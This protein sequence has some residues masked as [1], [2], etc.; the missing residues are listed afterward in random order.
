MDTIP[1]I[2]TSNVDSGGGETS[3]NSLGT[4]SSSS[5]SGQN[6]SITPLI[7]SPTPSSPTVQPKKKSIDDF[8]IGKV[9]GEGSYGAVVLGTD[10]ETQVQYAIKILEKKHIIKEN[11]IKYV[12][13][14]K[15]IF[16]KCNHPN[17]VKLFFT[18]RSDACLYYVLE[19]CSQG[20]LLHQLK[21]VG[22]FDA[23]CTRYYIAEIISAVEHL[24]QLGIVHRDLK[25]EN[26][27]MSADMHIK[28]TDFGTGKIMDKP[29]LTQTNSSS[30]LSDSTSTSNTTPNTSTGNLEQMVDQ[31]S[32]STDGTANPQ[33]L[34]KTRANSFVGTAEY[35]SPELISNKETSTDSD[36]WALG[37]ILYQLTTGRLPFR[38]KTE[39]LTFQK[40]SNRDLVYP[41]NINPVTKDLIGKLLVMKPSDR[42][43]SLSNGGFSELKKHEFF[44]GFDWDQ[45]YKMPPPPI[46]APKE[47]I[48]FDDS[49]LDLSSSLSS[50]L[51]NST[52]SVNTLSPL[53]TSPSNSSSNNLISNTTS[54]GSS[55]NLKPPTTTNN[56]INNNSNNTSTNNNAIVEKL[57]KFLNAGETIL[58]QGLVWKRK[59]FSIKKRHLILTSTPRLIYVDP[60]KMEF[61]GEIPWSN[62]IKPEVKGNSG[63]FVIQTPKRKYNMEDLDHNPQKWVDSITNAINNIKI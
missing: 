38:G 40:V 11:K 28:I 39:F 30:S 42:L 63:N 26:I 9:L 3:P 37:C 4:S 62:Q 2:T 20:D 48:V 34:Q 43:G 16:C 7:A 47:K 54:S 15:E 24:H 17:I 18:F 13:I 50:P 5:Y 41:T 22:S 44:Q 8:V 32:A 53:I 49:S 57:N 25:P 61:R 52:N 51:S 59:G 56:N 45:L 35:V 33:Q 27:L 14:E 23:D 58:E 21:K 31:A 36:L 55:S 6:I 29:Q 12:Q 19:L 60:K 46:Q 10:K 1:I